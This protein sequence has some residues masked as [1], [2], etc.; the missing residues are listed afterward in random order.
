MGGDVDQ[1]GYN[2]VVIGAPY[3]KPSG[4][5]FVYRGGPDGVLKLAQEFDGTNFKP[6]QGFGKVKAFGLSLSADVD[7]DNNKYPDLL[8]GTSSEFVVLLRSRPVITL[9]TALVVEPGEIDLKN[10]SCAVA[11]GPSGACFQV[12]VCYSYEARH[13]EQD[14]DL[15]IYYKLSFDHKT[16]EDGG[17]PRTMTADGLHSFERDTTINGSGSEFQC[18]HTFNVF[19]LDSAKDRISPVD[20]HFE[21]GLQSDRQNIGPQL[22]RPGEDVYEMLQLPIMDA[23]YQKEDTKSVLI[24]SNCGDDGCQ[25]NLKISASTMPEIIAGSDEVI[26]LTIVATN[27]EEEAHQ[28][29]IKV[30]LPPSVTYINASLPENPQGKLSCRDSLARDASSSYVECDIG[31]P[32]LG[33]ETIQILINVKEISALLE[34]ITFNVSARTTSEN[35]VIQ[36]IPVTSKVTIEYNLSISGTQ[37]PQQIRYKNGTILGESAIQFVSQIGPE[38]DYNFNIR[39]L[40]KRPAKDIELEVEFPLEIYNGKWLLYLFSASPTRGQLVVGQCFS[41]DHVINA[42]EK[43]LDTGDFNRIR[44]RRALKQRK[45]P[46]LVV[47]RPTRQQNGGSGLVLDCKTN[48]CR[49]IRC[50]LEEIPGEATIAVKF[51]SHVWEA[52]FLEEFVNTDIIYLKTAGELVS[53]RRNVRI[54]GT[55]M[56]EIS[57]TIDHD[58]IQVDYVYTFPWWYILIAV[59]LALIVYL[60]IIFVMY[61]CG[62]FKRNRRHRTRT[63]TPVEE[64]PVLV[65]EEKRTESTG[66]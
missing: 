12:K 27:D 44:S 36:T 40:G 37:R 11:D 32:F 19:F 42:L 18:D 23:D 62:F 45:V 47:P 49:K 59:I 66:V 25:S 57:T 7:I 10:S 48:L 2:D 60:I 34:M 30:S 8:V 54:V 3:H 26:P 51:V 29:F 16:V 39:N 22:Q 6:N 46:D 9:K 63:P 31:N 50:E 24:A 21:I 15:E 38:L 52:T 17:I 58:P 41:D 65:E 1:D 28:S 20:V 14:G 61:T 5:V 4:K 43:T 64:A 53:Q 33:K 56:T 13:G 55:S 35:P